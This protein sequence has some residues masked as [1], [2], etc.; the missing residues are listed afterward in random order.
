MHA[1]AGPCAG[2]HPAYK[3]V[4][5]ALRAVDAADTFAAIDIEASQAAPQTTA[6]RR[7][8]PLF[9]GYSTAW[10]R[11]RGAFLWTKVRLP[12]SDLRLGRISAEHVRMRRSCVLAKGLLS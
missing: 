2:S 3:A 4:A 11:E 8:G 9:R 10:L 6:P 1:C 12:P 7:T 5:D